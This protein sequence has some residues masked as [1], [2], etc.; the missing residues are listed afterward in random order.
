MAAFR[1][2]A[3][4]PN[5]RRA[6]LSF[7]AVWTGEWAVTVALGILAFREGGA[8]AV[9]LVAMARLLPGALLAPLSSGVID[10]RR[11]DSVLLVI[12]LIRAVTL[13]AA[14]VAVSELASPVPA[15]ALVAIA[16]V[17]LTLYRPAH[18][19]LLPSLCG[20]PTKLSAS[21]VVRGLLDS[22]S[23]LVGP[24]L[25][26]VLIVPIGVSGVF[27]LCA[28]ITLWSGW[29]IA[30]V[31]YEA[32]P[33][34][35]RAVTASPL[36]ESLKGL[37]LMVR[38]PDVRRMSALFCLQTFT[39][40]CFTVFSVVVAIEMLGT[41]EAGVGVLT[42]AFGAGAVAGSFVAAG[43]MVGEVPF[44]RWSGVAI[45]LWGLPFVVLAAVSSEWLALALIAVVGV[46]NALLD[47]AG[48]TLLQLIVPDEVMGRFFTGLESLFTLTVAIG[49][50]AAPLLIATFGE[51]G[52]LVVAGLVAPAGALLAWGTLRRLDIRIEVG[53]RVM[54]L[55]R[56]VDFLSSLPMATLAHL[57]TQA[58][59]REVEPGTVV[60]EEGTTGDDFYVIVDG[61]AEVL[62]GDVSVTVL[63]AGECFGEIAALRHVDRTSSIRAA[64]SLLLLRLSGDHLVWAVSG[65][66]PSRE[67][68][69]ALV[70]A[71][72]AAAYSS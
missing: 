64:T 69:D 63:G 35:L 38:D 26:A 51:R 12:C 34:V 10:A 9:G 18:S 23:A 52:A 33:R 16:T 42:A 11:R 50:I 3:S 41:G 32:P 67:A 40:G 45:A 30:R 24:L 22:L 71:R 2:T 39:R 28:G 15:Y 37:A 17:V 66:T 59:G 54:A 70:E 8:T 49:S 36:Q 61:S 25:V 20:T 55:L 31:H 68:A 13:A 57:A 7:G 19:A 56:R 29:L 14:A 48:F 43:V 72:L 46:A 58:S 62:R 1:E 6:Q 44:A 47:V 4:S 5:L 27:A 60:I 21:M 65:Y 53:A